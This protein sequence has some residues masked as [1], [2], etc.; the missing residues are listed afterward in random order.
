MGMERIT[1]VLQNVLSNYDIDIM[2][3][4][5]ATTER[6]TGKKYGVDPIAD[7]SYRVIDD[8]SRAVSCL[9]ADGVTPSNEGR[10]Y[11][12]RRLLRRAARHGRLIGLKQPFLH[13]VAKTVT[14]VMAMPTRI[15]TRGTAYSRGHS[16]RRRTLRRDS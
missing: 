5:T 8:H 4:L 14:A 10:G 16:H 9:I 6:L 1:A 2:R 15:E 12:L 13:E 11:V 3:E 7:I